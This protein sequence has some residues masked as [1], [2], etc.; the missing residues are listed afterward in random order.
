MFPNY[1]KKLWKMLI[2]ITLLSLLGCGTREDEPVYVFQYRECF[3]ND[4]ENFNQFKARD[5]FL[6]EFE[7]QNGTYK[8][9]LIEKMGA[10]DIIGCTGDF[11]YAF[12]CS[13]SARGV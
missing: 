10:Q 11:F 1:K 7:K 12:S 3:D 8:T 4:N 2:S 5:L 9:C 13:A 6:A